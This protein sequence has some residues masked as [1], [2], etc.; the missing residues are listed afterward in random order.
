MNGRY[1][2]RAAL[3]ALVAE[4]ER[5]AATP[6]STALMTEPRSLQAVRAAIVGTWRLVSHPRLAAGRPDRVLDVGAPG[7]D[8]HL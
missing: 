8:H 1:L 6:H 2:D 3:D 4:A 5:A 7:G